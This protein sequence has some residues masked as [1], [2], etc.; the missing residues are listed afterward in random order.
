MS[1]GCCFHRVRPPWSLV[2]SSD[3]V[4][5]PRVGLSSPQSFPGTK[6]KESQVSVWRVCVEAGSVQPAWRTAGL[7]RR[8]EQTERVG[9]QAPGFGSLA[10]YRRWRAV[11]RR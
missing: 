4:N 1:S 2:L 10:F 7:R 9:C 5:V 11:E 3:S 8:C 6:M